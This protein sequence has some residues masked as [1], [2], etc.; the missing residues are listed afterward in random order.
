MNEI[1]YEFNICRLF[2]L[3]PNVFTRWKDHAIKKVE[4]HGYKGSMS[5][6][7]IPFTVHI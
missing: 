2:G 3:S 7:S 1:L 4:K 6:V 5:Q